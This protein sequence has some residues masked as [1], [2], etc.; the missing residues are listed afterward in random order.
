MQLYTHTQYSQPQSIPISHFVR[1]NPWKR[2]TDPTAFVKATRKLTAPY[3]H[4]SAHVA[5]YEADPKLFSQLCGTATR[6]FLYIP[7]GAHVILPGNDGLLLRITSAPR[8]ERVAGF[9]VAHRRI[10]HAEYNEGCATCDAAVEKIIDSADLVSAL[11]RG[12]SVEPYWAITRDVEILGSLDIG[13]GDWR[14]FASPASVGPIASYW[15]PK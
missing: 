2:L 7:I 12:S 11:E 14:H 10:C 4:S 6:T 3:A 1:Q 13:S 5:A 9:Y 8:A 15:T